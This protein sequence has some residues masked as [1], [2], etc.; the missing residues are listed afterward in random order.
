MYYYMSL[1]Y[2]IGVSLLYKYKEDVII[3]VEKAIKETQLTEL[4][5]N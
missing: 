1:F 3:N 5:A 4:S 2:L